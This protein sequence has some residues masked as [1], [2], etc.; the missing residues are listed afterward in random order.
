MSFFLSRLPDG[1]RVGK[2][3]ALT[4][5]KLRAMETVLAGIATDLIPEERIPAFVERLCAT[6]TSDIR[7]IN[8]ITDEFVRGSPSEK[9]WEE[10]GL[11]GHLQK[12]FE[13]CFKNEKLQDIFKALEKENT[14]WAKDTLQRMRKYSPTYM[15][16]VVE[17][18]K[19]GKKKDLASCFRM[20]YR[21]AKAFLKTRDLQTGVKSV[22]IDKTKEPPEW[23]PPLDQVLDK[24]AL[25]DSE[26][27]ATF[28]DGSV[29]GE[30]DWDEEVRDLGLWDG[31]TYMDYPHRTVAGLPREEDVR[32]VVAGKNECAWEANS[33]GS[34][35][36]T[37][38]EVLNWF[39]QNWGAFLDSSTLGPLNALPEGVGGRK[40]F[41]TQS[42]DPLAASSPRGKRAEAW[43]IRQVRKHP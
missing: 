22:L 1:S 4:G 16:V 41:I 11:N 23:N 30:E 28:F 13:R 37:S 14:E 5:K 2:Y 6:P 32:V 39:A 40:H 18:L 15:K 27:Q 42:K 12:A 3:L 35:A 7:A 24:K 29:K 43:L 19:R 21:I 33:A 20:E 26:V 8:L 9:D 25:P 36:M 17:E 38:E 10:W 34:F 31:R